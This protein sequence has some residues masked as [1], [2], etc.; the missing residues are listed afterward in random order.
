[1]AM[2]VPG[3]LEFAFTAEEVLQIEKLTAFLG[4]R[5]QRETVMLA[6]NWL[7]HTSEYMGKHMPDISG[8]ENAGVEYYKDRAASFSIYAQEAFN[9]LREIREGTLPDL[10]WFHIDAY[11]TQFCVDYGKYAEKEVG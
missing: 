10:D 11:H 6:I 2:T 4:A 3:E 7:Q 1:M 9:Y 5:T 8:R